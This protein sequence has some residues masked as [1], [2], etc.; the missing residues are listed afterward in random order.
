MPLIYCK[1]YQAYKRIPGITSLS[2]LEIHFIYDSCQI[3]YRLSLLILLTA[4]ILRSIAE[5]RL[6]SSCLKWMQGKEH[7]HTPDN[8]YINYF[9]LLIHL[10]IHEGGR[11]KTDHFQALLGCLSA[12]TLSPC[13]SGAFSPRLLLSYQGIF[14]SER[15]L[16]PFSAASKMKQFQ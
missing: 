16:K 15:G 4:N 3:P 9:V 2:L 8:S 1:F 6:M 5:A 7:T 10:I 14:C 12:T 13:F 11:G